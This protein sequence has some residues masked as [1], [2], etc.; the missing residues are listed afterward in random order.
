[1]RAKIV[2]LSIG[3]LAVAAPFF[4]GDTGAIDIFG[5]ILLICIAAMALNLITGLGG[6]ISL[7]HAALMGVGAYTAGVLSSRLDIDFF[8]GLGVTVLVSALIGLLFG[9]PSLRVRGQYLALVTVGGG[10]VFTRVIAEARFAGGE[11]GLIDVGPMVAFGHSLDLKG[12]TAVI[13]ILFL[14]CLYLATTVTTSRI[15]RALT[16]IKVSERGAEAAGIDTYRVKLGTFVGSSVM[17]GMAGALFA[18]KEGF[19]SPSTF[20]FDLSLVLIMACIVGGVGRPLG[21]VIGAFVFAGPFI[22]YP[23]AARYQLAILGP[24]ALI[25]LLFFPEGIAG[26]VRSMRGS[27]G[28]S[29]FAAAEPFAVAPVAVKRSASSD[30]EPLLVASNISKHF[31][32][33]AALDD[34]SLQVATG[35]VHALI[36][37]NGSGKTS[38]INC[39]TG[40]QRS[41]AG[42]V[43]F[44]G[45]AVQGRPHLIA[46]KGVARTFQEPLTFDGLSMLEDVAIGA[47]VG[48]KAGTAACLLGTRSSK[49]GDA[50]AAGWASQ[51]LIAVGLDATEA[52]KMRTDELSYGQSKR[53]E[54][55]RAIAMQPR[56]LILDEPS[57][58]KDPTEIQALVA[59]LGELKDRG[60]T[61]LLVDHHM[62]LVMNV[63]DKV[64]VL[65][66]GRVVASGTPGEITRDQRVIDAYLGDAPE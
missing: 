11:S 14:I 19:V 66:H 37:P 1:M 52:A 8:A 20:G 45:S 44:D 2:A 42:E 26:K 21:G 24:I 63:A 40:V 12:Q 4:M 43:R 56:L 5:S 58:G 25:T 13:A 10:F 46:R 32:G 62:D 54:M 16:A 47:K 6:Q 22:A 3:A 53:L 29:D 31:G 17:A 39:I 33:V 7:G 48:A 9:A 65:D 23:G 55:A 57:A 34:V 35:S 38:F 49:R 41:D 27:G 51:A 61:I 36:G 15:G 50:L 60:M 18:H 64:T 28:L 30:K 59:L